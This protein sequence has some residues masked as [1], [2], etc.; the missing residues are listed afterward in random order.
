MARLGS[1]TGGAARWTSR[2][3][4]LPGLLFAAALLMV[5]T[6]L[7]AEETGGAVTDP[8]SRAEELSREGV[9]AYQAG[10][11][12]DA[13]AAMLEARGILSEHGRPPAPEL[14]YNIARIYHK[15]GDKRL[16]HESYTRFILV[17]GA[18][19]AMVRKALDYREQ[20]ATATSDATRPATGTPGPPADPEGL[21]GTSG[22]VADPGAGALAASAVERPVTT[23]ARVGIWLGAAGLAI[24]S[25]GAVL[26]GLAWAA[27]DSLS[28]KKSFSARK[29]A[30]DRGKALALAADITLA[31]G[32]AMVTTATVL[33]LLDNGD[34]SP[35]PRA[36]MV[37]PYVFTG[38]GGGVGAS[39]SASF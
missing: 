29:D 1:L 3:A 15:M 24:V 21:S 27:D 35:E 11:Y 5:A 7:H 37:S 20:V 30:Q 9:E 2:A 38:T 33:L 39:V 8:I 23:Q 36:F 13:I 28:D 31:S 14:L 16:A 12:K 22:A 25:G 17:D 19:P 32:L 18:D 4:W 26:G 10:R 34:E 6:T